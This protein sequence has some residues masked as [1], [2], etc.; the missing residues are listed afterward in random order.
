MVYA[1]WTNGVFLQFGKG[2]NSY[3]YLVFSLVMYDLSTRT[4]SYSFLFFPA[5]ARILGI[6]MEGVQALCTLHKC[7][8]SVGDLVIAF[9]VWTR[10]LFFCNNLRRLLL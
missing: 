2:S 3:W 1:T 4:L 7:H 6:E 10:G 9:V 8:P 5:R